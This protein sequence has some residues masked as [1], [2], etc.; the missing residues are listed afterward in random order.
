MQFKY[1]NC[2][3]IILLLDQIGDQSIFIFIHLVHLYCIDIDRDVRK[4]KNL[5]KPLEKDEIKELFGELGLF[6]ATLRKKYSDNDNVYADYL[7]RL[8]IRGDDDAQQLEDYPGGATWENLKKA[9]TKLGRTGI[10]EEIK[11]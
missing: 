2:M 5:L 11:L 9:L 4:V 8:W 6:D 7:V 10:A 3:W 1:W